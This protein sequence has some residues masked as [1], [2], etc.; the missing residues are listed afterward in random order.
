[1]EAAPS[2]DRAAAASSPSP[3]TAGA[4]PLAGFFLLS[5]GWSW[6]FWGAAVLAGFGAR[7]TPGLLL[8]LL[9]GLG[10]PLAG[11]VMTAV[12]GGRP[13]LRELGGRIVS[14]RRIGPKWWAAVLS[15]PPLTLAGAVAVAALLRVPGPLADLS[16][17]KSVLH[18]PAM[19][20]SFILGALVVGPL[21][22]EIGW[23]GYALDALQDRTSALNASLLLGGARALWHLPLFFVV[24]YYASGAPEPLLFVA[25]ILLDSILF[26]WIHNHTRRSVLAAILFHFAINAC[27]ALV[28][29]G[30][31][32]AWLQALLTGALAA[33]VLVY[34]GPATLA[35]ARR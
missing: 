21:P 13:G 7:E 27:A 24:G 18:E 30:R 31:P 10:P 26:T 22:E 25:V 32:V 34:A 5:H 6:T 16:N 23:R 20:V 9:G 29:L 33:A 2:I 4:R 12:S 17:A 35:R 3:S 11:V 19:L 1:M 28:V 14:P 8:L 15:I